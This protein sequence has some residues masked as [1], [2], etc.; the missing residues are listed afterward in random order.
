MNTPDEL[1]DRIARLDPVTS[2]ATIQSVT[3]PGAKALLEDIM[4]TPLSSDTQPT[5]TQTNRPWWI[6]AGV[7]AAVIAVVT[8]G[9]AALN[10]NDDEPTIAEPSVTE[11][12]SSD[13]SATSEPAGKL[14]VLELSAGSEDVM[15]SCLRLDPAMV[16][17][18]QVAFRGTGASVEGEIVT[19]TID[20]WYVGGDAQVATL[21]APAGMQA[22][23]GGIAFEPG[24]S[25]IVAAYDGVVSYCGLTGEATPELE[26]IYAEAFP[27]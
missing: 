3:S 2:D 7:A 10:R 4:N 5:T 11:S 18:S 6:S 21:V 14:K 22:L 25:Y 23:I 15:A 13:S 19:L 16:A 27:G 24:K 1:R 12:D 26:A 9:V 17:M 20:H 8:I